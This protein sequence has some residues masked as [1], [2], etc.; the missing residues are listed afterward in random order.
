[1]QDLPILF[2]KTKSHDRFAQKVEQIQFEIQSVDQD[3]LPNLVTENS[4]ALILV[5]D[6]T[7]KEWGSWHKKHPQTHLVQLISKKQNLQDQGFI[8]WL[9]EHMP[10]EEF[11][12][13]LKKAHQIHCQLNELIANDLRYKKEREIQNQMNDRLLAVSLELKQAKEKIEQLSITDALTQL[14][15]RRYFDVEA[16]KEIHKAERYDTDLCLLVLDIDNFKY[17]NDTYGHQTGDEVLQ[18]LGVLIKSSLRD[19][20]WAAR[21]GGEEFCVI[22]PMTSEKG[23]LKVAERLRSQIEKQLGKDYKETFTTSLGL[24]KFC[25]GLNL[26]EWFEGADKALYHSKQTGKNKVT[27]YSN[28]TRECSEYTSGR[29]Q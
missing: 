16:L 6:P 11:D 29:A 9:D 14:G 28:Q 13:R 7:K 19:T 1:M 2:L 23:A 20:D 4:N 27:F 15:N 18:K 5:C 24:S 3:E 21:Y 25:K 22:L 8:E 10:Q 26:N 17:I 12:F